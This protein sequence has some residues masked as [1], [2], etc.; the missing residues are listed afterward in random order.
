LALAAFFP[1]DRKPT[2]TPAAFMESGSERPGALAGFF[3]NRKGLHEGK[4]A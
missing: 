1:D 4:D 2:G 3:V